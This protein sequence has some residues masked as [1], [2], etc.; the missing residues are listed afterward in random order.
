VLDHSSAIV[1]PKLR[2]NDNILLYALNA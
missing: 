2:A 1:L